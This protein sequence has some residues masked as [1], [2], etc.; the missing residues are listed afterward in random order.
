MTA[1]YDNDLL[2][3][4]ILRFKAG[5]L[6]SAR[7]FFVRAL[8]VADDTQTRAA[9][10]FYLSQL[11]DDPKKK[12]HYLEETLGMDPVHAGA[13]RA[14]AILDGRLKPEE[15]IDPD[16]LPAPAPG[17]VN[18][19]ADR[20]T[21]PKCGGRMVYAA[22]GKSLTC[23]FCARTQPL[24][25]QIAGEQDFFAAMASSRGHATAV[26]TQ[27]FHCQGCG[28]E[29]I[30]EAQE[31]SAACA[32]CGSPH[33]VRQS[34]LLSAPDAILPFGFDQ[35]EAA[36][37]LQSWV[38]KKALEPAGSLP[39]LHPLYLPV[40]T[41][42]I[43]GT[44]PWSGK[45]YRNQQLVPVSGEEAAYYYNI[46]V[47]AAKKYSRLFSALLEGINFSV[48]APYDPR[49]L[50]GWPAEVPAISLSDAALE[51][52][53]IAVERVRRLMHSE[54]GVVEDL[55]YQ[56][57]AIAVDAYHL[58]LVPLWLAEV[59]QA[60]DSI[61]VMIDGVTGVVHGETPGRGLLGW[62]GDLFGA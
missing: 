20:F 54:H 33:V 1:D 32:W 27:V 2:R 40:W 50:A 59:P 44:I 55:R 3:E 14:L 38:E 11:T 52:R 15:I 36:R 39:L 56:S 6:D 4:G 25:D 46:V 22:D 18:V 35:K 24:G 10:C 26:S 23:E 5:E 13:R 9:A 41:F 17:V 7:R 62:L 53:R 42:D 8:D 61:P 28:A 47:P 48:T 12:R 58:V 51:A 34:R 57:S 16:A 31:L 49:Y 43:V 60:G 21:C 37:C 30:L 19:D 45:V 29:F